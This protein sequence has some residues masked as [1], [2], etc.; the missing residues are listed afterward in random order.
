VCEGCRFHEYPYEAQIPVKINETYEVRMFGSDD[1]V[2]DV[3]DLIIEETQEYNKEGRSF[4]IA[5]SVSS[6]LPFFACRN[7]MLDEKAQKDIS[8]FMYSKE[9][10]ISSYKGSYGE[11]PKKWVEKSFLLKGL[12]NS[13]TEKAQ[14]KVMK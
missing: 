8:R 7:I 11:Q 10:G 1:D 13:A 14:K 5:E 2:W 12:V 4:S 6:Q 3:I 9:F